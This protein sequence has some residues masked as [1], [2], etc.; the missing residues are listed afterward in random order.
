M[1]LREH[2]VKTRDDLAEIETLTQ[3]LGQEP[4]LAEI[5]SV[6]RR[7][8]TLVTRLKHGECQLSAQDPQWSTRVAMDP[9]CKKLFEESRSLLGYVADLDGRLSVLIESR[10]AQVRQQLSSLYNAS[11]AAYSYTAHSIIQTVR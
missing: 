5:E 4:S 8:D 3:N 10:M 9:S 1:D 7:R 2:L 6:L 11:R